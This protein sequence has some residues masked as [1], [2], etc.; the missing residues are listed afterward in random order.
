MYARRKL[1]KSSSAN[2]TRYLPSGSIHRFYLPIANS[3]SATS[4]IVMIREPDNTRETFVGV[5]I[6]NHYLPLAKLAGFE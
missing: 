4:G 6:Y 2:I 3:F 5:K 1:A